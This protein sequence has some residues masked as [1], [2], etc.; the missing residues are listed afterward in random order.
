MLGKTLKIRNLLL[1]I[2]YAS[3]LAHIPQKTDGLMKWNCILLDSHYLESLV[4]KYSKIISTEIQEIAH[5]LMEIKLSNITSVYLKKNPISRLCD[6]R[7][8]HLENNIWKIHLW[9][10]YWVKVE[11]AAINQEEK[12]KFSR[13]LIH[14]LWLQTCVVLMSPLR[15]WLSSRKHAFWG[16]RSIA[17]KLH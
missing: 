11:E 8:I 17:L 10:I 13:M 16:L 3:Q 14:F 6:A 9:F 4:T 15:T 2:L 12:L 1:W 7:I 5:N